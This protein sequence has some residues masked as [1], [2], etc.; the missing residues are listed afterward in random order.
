MAEDGE[1]RLLA[2]KIW[3]QEGR[4]DGKDVEHYL[5]AKAMLEEQEAKRVLELAA[6]VP[7]SELP[8]AAHYVELAPPT[9]LTALP[10]KGV[11]PVIRGRPKKK[12][13]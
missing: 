12:A 11:K 2:Y 10:K 5:Q 13:K 4:P 6:P 1:I 8:A 9:V 7:I 3:Q